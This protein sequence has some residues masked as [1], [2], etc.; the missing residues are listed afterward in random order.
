MRKDGIPFEHDLDKVV[1]EFRPRGKGP[2]VVVD[3]ADNIG[4]GGPG[5]CTDV[6]RA[7]LK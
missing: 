5:D 2:V 6:M 4:G 3:P 1:R 7:F